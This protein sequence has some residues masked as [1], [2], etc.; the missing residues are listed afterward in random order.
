MKSP[1][2]SANKFFLKVKNFKRYINSA[3][4]SNIKKSPEGRQ[5]TLF[6]VFIIN[7]DHV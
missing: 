5:L 7:F 6:A 3:Y 4:Y 2:F 1:F